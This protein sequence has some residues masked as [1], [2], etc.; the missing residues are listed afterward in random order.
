[1][2]KCTECDGGV[3]FSRVLH[4]A[5]DRVATQ[6]EKCDACNVYASDEDATDAVQERWGAITKGDRINAM[7]VVVEQLSHKL[8][9]HRSDEGASD[10][11]WL[12]RAHLTLVRLAREASEPAGKEPKTESGQS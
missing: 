9:V 3:V 7:C 2:S 11:E 4:V 5:F 6:L 8:R 10:P 1:M 12:R